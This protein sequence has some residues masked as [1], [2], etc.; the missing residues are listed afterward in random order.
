MKQHDTAPNADPT[1]L[2]TVDEV[3]RHLRIGRNSV[4]KLILSGHLRTI[5]VGRR[6]RLCPRSEVERYITAQLA[7]EYGDDN[8]P[9]AA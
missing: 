6:R 3:A 5:S 2:L 1:L 7:E 4:Y 9:P 8:S